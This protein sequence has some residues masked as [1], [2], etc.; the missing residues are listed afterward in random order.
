MNYYVS[1]C[2]ISFLDLGILGTGNSLLWEAVL[3]NVGC[4]A[5]AL[6]PH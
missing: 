4:M 2:R 5:P 3:Y 1:L 6:D